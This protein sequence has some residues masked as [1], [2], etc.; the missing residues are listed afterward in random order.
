[1]D[2]IV[3]SNS[4][5][6]IGDNAS[7]S[8]GLVRVQEHP[9]EALEFYSFPINNTLISSWTNDR[10]WSIHPKLHVSIYTT[11]YSWFY[12]SR[13]KSYVDAVHITNGMTVNDDSQNAELEK[14][15]VDKDSKLCIAGGYVIY[16]KGD[17]GVRIDGTLKFYNTDTKE[18]T[19]T[20][21]MNGVEQKIV[22][23]DSG[24]LD[25]EG[26]FTWIIQGDEDLKVELTNPIISSS[27]DRLGTLSL[28]YSSI[29]DIVKYKSFSEYLDDPE[30]SNIK[31]FIAND[32][33]IRFTTRPN[34][35]AITF[36][37][38]N[39]SEEKQ[40]GNDKIWSIVDGKEIYL[41]IDGA[42]YYPCKN[43]ANLDGV[44]IHEGQSV[45]TGGNKTMTEMTI[46]GQVRVQGDITFAVNSGDQIINVGENGKIV[47]DDTKSLTISPTTGM[48][49]ENNGGSITGTGTCTFKADPNKVEYCTSTAIADFINNNDITSTVILT[50]IPE[51]GESLTYYFSN[52]DE[53][54][55]AWT[56]NDKV[57]SL[58]NGKRVYVYTTRYYYPGMNAEIKDN[59]VIPEGKIVTEGV[60]GVSF[61]DM[62]VD[63]T[64]KCTDSHIIYLS[65]NLSI[66]EN[67]SLIGLHAKTSNAGRI[68]I[69]NYSKL[70]GS[71]VPTLGSILNNFVILVNNH[72]DT[73]MTFYSSMNEM[74]WGT[75]YQ[76]SLR[77]D[78]A[79]YVFINGGYYY[80]GS[81]THYPDD[82]VVI[83]SG[84]TI[85]DNVTINNLNT[86]G[87][88]TV[89]SGA[90]FNQYYINDKNV[91]A[92][93]HLK[94]TGNVKIDGQIMS[95]ETSWSYLYI[96][97]YD[98]LTFDADNLD[99]INSGHGCILVYDVYPTNPTFYARTVGEKTYWSS[100]YC[101]QLNKQGKHIY[102]VLPDGVWYYPGYNEVND[103]NVVIPAGV[104]MITNQ[105]DK[106]VKSM[107][108]DGQLN[109]GGYRMNVRDGI[110]G[111]GRLQESAKENLK[112]LG[113]T[114]E[115]DKYEIYNTG[116]WTHITSTN[117]YTYY[118]N[119]GTSDPR[120]W[121][122]T[123]RLTENWWRADKC[124]KD[125][126][127]YTK[128]SDGNYEYY[129]PRSSNDT[130]TVS[131]GE[132]IVI[133]LQR[134]TYA[135]VVNVEGTLEICRDSETIDRSEKSTDDGFAWLYVSELN[136]K[137]S[138]RIILCEN[139][140]ITKEG[141]GK[142]LD[143]LNIEGGSITG[144][145]IIYVN[146]I[147]YDKSSSV[148]KDFVNQ[149]GTIRVVPKTAPDTY[150]SRMPVDESGAHTGYLVSNDNWSLDEDLKSSVSSYPGKNGPN[151]NL[152]VMPDD[153]VS[154]N[155]NNATFDNMTL[156]SGSTFKVNGY[157]LNV[158]NDINNDGNLILGSSRTA[159]VNGD[160]KGSGIVT[161]YSLENLIVYGKPS[162]KKYWSGYYEGE[163]RMLAKPL[164]ELTF[165]A[166]YSGDWV[167]G[168]NSRWTMDPDGNKLYL[169]DNSFGYVSPGCEISGS[170]N[171]RNSDNVVIKSG[172]EITV[173]GDISIDNLT[174]E[175]GA[176]LRICGGNLSV[177]GTADIKGQVVICDNGIDGKDGYKLLI[178]GGLNVVDN[179]CL[180]G[181]GWISAPNE[182]INKSS[183]PGR[184]F[185]A[186]GGHIHKSN[187]P[188]LYKYNASEGNW[189]TKACWDVWD[190]ETSTWKSQSARYP[191]QTVGD[192]A[193]VPVGSKVI[194]NVTVYLSELELNG[195]VTHDPKPDG[196]MPA[197]DDI[198]VSEKM[199]G[200]GILTLHCLW[201]IHISGDN[202][203]FSNYVDEHGD[204]QFA[205]GITRVVTSPTSGG[206]SPLQ[207]F[208]RGT[209]NWKD[210]DAVWSIDED[211]NLFWYPYNSNTGK[212]EYYYPYKN[213][214]KY[215]V[216][217]PAGADITF[218]GIDSDVDNS[219]SV[220]GLT[221]DGKLTICGSVLTVDGKTVVN[222][223]I[224]ICNDDP[225]NETTN[226]FQCTGYI[227]LNGVITG[228]DDNGT[229]RLRV[230]AENKIN[231]GAHGSYEDILNNGQLLITSRIESVQTFYSAQSGDWKSN[232]KSMWKAGDP[233]KNIYY[234]TT[235]SEEYE[236]RYTELV[237]TPTVKKDES[238]NDV[239]DEMG[240]PVYEDVVTSVEKSETR[241]K[242]VYGY[243]APGDYQYAYYYDRVV[244]QS[245]HTMTL[246]LDKLCYIRTLEVEE[247]ATL[248]VT[249]GDTLRV[250][251]YTG[252]LDVTVNGKMVLCDNAVLRVNSYLNGTGEL[253][254]PK[255]ENLVMAYPK[256]NNLANKDG[257]KIIFTSLDTP[258][259]F[260]S[261][262]YS[263]DWTDYRNWVVDVVNPLDDTQPHWYYGYTAFNGNACDPQPSDMYYPGKLNQADC[264][265]VSEGSNLILDAPVTLS[266]IEINGNLTV[267]QSN[268]DNAVY[269]TTTGDMVGSSDG[270]LTLEYAENIAVQGDNNF[271]FVGKIVIK[272][273]TEG[274]VFYLY[275]SDRD[276]TDPLN[277]S[278]DPNV[279]TNEFFDGM[280]QRW[281]Y[282]GKVL[283]D[284][285]V[286]PNGKNARVNKNVIVG[287]LK[288]EYGGNIFYDDDQIKLAVC[289]K[290]D[291]Y[292]NSYGS[293]HVYDLEKNYV[294]LDNCV[295]NF[296]ANGT[297]EV[298]KPCVI[299]AR[300]YG[301]LIVN[302]ASYANANPPADDEEYQCRV[303]GDITINKNLDVENG[304]VLTLGKD[305]LKIYY[306]RAQLYAKAK[307]G[308]NLPSEYDVF[309]NVNVKGNVTV[310]EGGVLRGASVINDVR[311]GILNYT[312]L[313]VWSNMD[314]Y[315]DLIV[316]GRLDFAVP[317]D[318]YGVHGAWAYSD[319]KVVINFKGS[320]DAMFKVDGFAS[321]ISMICEKSTNAE[322]S[323]DKADDAEF[324]M[325]GKVAMPD[326]G[327]NS[328]SIVLNS[329]ILR[330]GSGIEVDGWG[331]SRYSSNGYPQGNLEYSIRNRTS[332]MALYHRTPYY[333]S[334]LVS[335]V[336]GNEG[337][338]WRVNNDQF[339]T[340]DSFKLKY[341]KG[342]AGW[343]DMES[344]SDYYLDLGTGLEYKW[345][346]A[347]TIFKRD[348]EE[349]MV[350]PAGAKLIIDGA[351][352][353]VGRGHTSGQIKSD[354]AFFGHMTLRG[355]LE[356]T[357][358][359][360]L[361]FDNY[362]V[363]IV[364]DNPDGDM[365]SPAEIAI[366]DGGKI[367]VSRIYGLHG[368]KLNFSM[369]GE[370]S[371]LNFNRNTNGN[372]KTYDDFFKTYGGG[373]ITKGKPQGCVFS[374][375]NGGS[376][377]MEDGRILF[378]NYDAAQRFVVN[379]MDL[380]NCS[381]HFG[382]G[383]LRFE[384][385]TTAMT[386]YIPNSVHLHDVSV[387]GDQYV[388][389]V[390]DGYDATTLGYS[391]NDLYIDGNLTI[392]MLKGRMR[393]PENLHVGGNIY[394]RQREGVTYT[395][396]INE[397]TGE[398]ELVASKYENLADQTKPLYASY[399]TG[400]NSPNL[401]IM[402]SENSVLEVPVESSSYPIFTHLTV[403]KTSPTATFT[404]K[405]RPF[406]MWGDLIVSRG[407]VITETEFRN[408]DYSHAVDNE[409]LDGIV[410]G[411]IKRV[412]KTQ[413]VTVDDEGDLSESTISTWGDNTTYNLNINSNVT[414]KNFLSNYDR[415]IILNN[416]VT[417]SVTDRFEMPTMNGNRM[418]V[419]P[420]ATDQIATGGLCVP[421]RKSAGETFT[422]PIGISYINANRALAYAY[423]RSVVT[424]NE[425]VDGYMQAMACNNWH[426]QVK[427]QS[428][429]TKMYWRM[430]WKD[431]K[432][433]DEETGE[434]STPLVASNSAFTYDFSLPGIADNETPAY[435]TQTRN[436]GNSRQHEGHSEGEVASPSYWEYTK[437]YQWVESD[438]KWYECGRRQ[439]KAVA[440]A[441]YPTFPYGT[442]FAG[443]EYSLPSHSGDF[444]DGYHFDTDAAPK[445][446]YSCANGEWDDCTSWTL[447]EDFVYDG[448]LLVP[449]KLDRVVIG[450]GYKITT[451]ATSKVQAAKMTINEDGTLDVS[452]SVGVVAKKSSKNYVG[453]I[454][455]E[456][457]LIYHVDPAQD[458]IK[459]ID[460]TN[461]L[462]GDHSEFLTNAKSKLVYVND[463]PE[464]VKLPDVITEYP[465]L[466]IEGNAQFVNTT[467]G[468]TVNG[469]LEIEKGLLE[470]GCA[471]S[472]NVT[473]KGDLVVGENGKLMTSE[474]ETVSLSFKKKIVNNGE[475]VLGK[476]SAD[477]E[478]DI[479]NNGEF[480]VAGP[481]N[482]VSIS[483]TSVNG[484]LIKISN[485]GVLVLNK[486]A[487]TSSLTV[488]AEIV[489]E[490]SD[491]IQTD[492]KRGVLNMSCLTTDAKF[493]TYRN[494]LLSQYYD[495]PL[496]VT[497]NVKAG[498]VE[499]SGTGASSLRLGGNLSVANA[500]LKT[501]NGL[502]YTTNGATMTLGENSKF[503]ASQIAPSGS[504]GAFKFNQASSNATVELV[505]STEGNLYNTGWGILDIR[506]GEFTQV[507]GA[508][509]DIK[510]S[511]QNV[512]IPTL[513]YQPSTS[514]L[515][516]NSSFVL[517]TNDD[518]SIY[519]AHALQGLNVA[520]GTNAAVNTRPLVL[521]STLVVDGELNMNDLNLTLNADAVI[522]GRYVSGD[523]TTYLSSAT[524]QTISG[525]AADVEFNNVV[526]NTASTTTIKLPQAIVNG[527]LSVTNGKLNIEDSALRMKGATATVNYTRSITGLGVEMCGDS[528]QQ[529]L[530]EG[531][532]GTLI[533]NN[534]NG[535]NASTSQT[536]PLK[537]SNELRMTDGVLYIGSN[538][539]ELA[540]TAQVTD[541]DGSGWRAGKLIKTNNVVA[542]AGIK[543][544]LPS[545]GACDFAIPMGTE[546][547]YTPITLEGSQS[548]PNAFVRIVPV[549]GHF[550][551]IEDNQK[552]H[553]MKYYWL[554]ESEGINDLNG[555]LHFKAEKS[556]ANGFDHD[557]TDPSEGGYVTAV[558]FDGKET[559]NLAEGII[560]DDGTMVLIDI[561]LSNVSSTGK[562][563]NGYYMAGCM[564]KLPTEVKTYISV[565]DGD[566]AEAIWK[567]YR[568]NPV[569]NIREVVDG[570]SFALTDAQMVGCAIYINSRVK[571]SDNVKRVGSVEIMSNA[572][573]NIG[574]TLNHF[575][576]Y[577]RGTGTM[578]LYS[579]NMPIANYEDFLSS[580]GGT[581]EFS[582]DAQTLRKDY[583]ILVGMTS[584]NHLKLSGEGKRCFRTDGG[585][586]D[587]YGTFT[588]DGSSNLEAQSNGP[589]R[590][591]GNVLVNSGQL[592]GTGTYVFCNSS[593]PQYLDNQNGGAITIGGVE[594][595]N[596]RGVTMSDGTDLSLTSLALTD[597]ILH[598]G[599]DNKVT[600]SG[601]LS[602]GSANSYVDGTLGVSMTS[603]QSLL[604]P[605]GE[606]NRYA[607]PVITA[608]KADVL[609]VRYVW[610]KADLDSGHKHNAFCSTLG[611][612]YWNIGYK[613]G[614]GTVSVKLPY[615]EESNI[616]ANSSDLRLARIYNDKVS[617]N[618]S[619]LAMK[620]S[621]SNMT[622]GYV[623]TTSNVSVY[624]WSVGG[625]SFAFGLNGVSDYEWTGKVSADWFDGNNWAGR[626]VPS[627][628]NE[629]YIKDGRGVYPVISNADMVAYARHIYIRGTEPTLTVNGGNLY[630]AWQICIED[631]QNQHMFINNR[632]DKMSNVRT[633]NILYGTGASNIN[634]LPATTHV[635]V[636]RTLPANVLCYTGSA[637][638]QGSVKSG[639]NTSNGDYLAQ[640]NYKNE[641]YS[642]VSSFGTSFIGHTIGLRANDSEP[643]E[644]SFVQ[645]GS[646]LGTITSYSFALGLT[647]GSEKTSSPYGWNLITNPYTFSFPLE[648]GVFVNS[649]GVQPVI[650]FRRF[651][652]E[653]KKYYYS[654]FSL[655]TYEGVAASTTTTKLT[656]DDYY[657]AP[658]EAFFVKTLSAKQSVKFNVGYVTAD[659]MVTNS[660]L[661]ARKVATDVLR[662]SIE[663]DKSEFIDEVAF[664][665]RDGGTMES[666]MND[667]DKRFEGNSYNQ[668]YSFKDGGRYA[669]PFYPS[670][671]EVSD[672]LMPLGIQLAAGAAEGTI[673]ATNLDVFDQN[674]EVYLYD[675]VEDIVVNLRETGEYQF[676][677][678]SGYKIDDRFA[679]GLVSNVEEEQVVKPEDENA[680]GVLSVA[681]DGMIMI[682]RNDDNE[683]VVS[684]SSSLLSEESVVNVYDM[685]GVLVNKSDIKSVKTRVKLGETK[686]V[687]IVE[688]ISGGRTKTAK[689]RSM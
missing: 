689:L 61:N 109:Q 298:L 493:V 359:G 95:P 214:S 448:N 67:A 231:L 364:Y 305:I 554:I 191:G 295:D 400:N 398:E 172:K 146:E 227:D 638:K 106:T 599:I 514:E 256:R 670:M 621:A 136:L 446:F 531:T 168:E 445:T 144:N 550:I 43:T 156:R 101:W 605:V 651:N 236:Y 234:F 55:N 544:Y 62:T 60:S 230:T 413:N 96:S 64:Y 574:N 132:H 355:A 369:S 600:V 115:N 258:V 467:K 145:G 279:Y 543:K 226:I 411:A 375:A 432:V 232:V 171:S 681:E 346:D 356:V 656:S 635:V 563:L 688:V 253:Y 155:L 85:Y 248:Y 38:T 672:V 321:I 217:I 440:G 367:N 477:I 623:C 241:T 618:W 238:G 312:G 63:G 594:I 204:Y 113:S 457:T 9:G 520:S 421:V 498:K 632:Y 393:T 428:T 511:A 265:V 425:D 481:I 328:W 397:E 320:N 319:R 129:Y 668:I 580:E 35:E 517:N 441:G 586:T 528:E 274:T 123:D 327:R 648:S 88:F 184:S 228:T 474:D 378:N 323:V 396:Q 521:N 470:L 615:D 583:N 304:S 471:S 81:N 202:P 631:G 338:V 412:N 107:V 602:G 368:R 45:R 551:G 75:T 32:G 116:E 1:M 612:E 373:D 555:S 326:Y 384:N 442:D 657:I 549:D 479:D 97:D 597:G 559:W 403:S 267:A 533:I 388:T 453:V 221:V 255:P 530:C 177:R 636:N 604:F 87:D 684:V 608:G 281:R 334:A 523:N 343:T 587:I 277:W 526:K 5:L 27:T 246:S 306:T 86:I 365:N 300:E 176:I 41:F 566:W 376:F 22:F 675:F 66:G 402:G 603:G 18:Y 518:I 36:Y 652:N 513:Y 83:Q 194:L 208:A 192:K 240:N 478:G 186:Q 220:A 382:G 70:I 535:V 77:R 439:T 510:G 358:N 611:N 139:A 296:L 592:T 642:N 216:Q 480:T 486:E 243:Y 676:T 454:L 540:S 553:V 556:D 360:V 548:S 650:W 667:A 185:V 643:L 117:P 332:N 392:D 195:E 133:S 245:G 370:D 627:A 673:S 361:N 405:G 401:F 100:S 436:C 13:L 452:K 105:N 641:G 189:N 680:T 426:P 211:A 284:V 181:G 626:I 379:G 48:K 593:S 174:V 557:S 233:N 264:V 484:N 49:W 4:M 73:A 289:F 491:Y 266:S 287:Y 292:N 173:N 257:G 414:V 451:D 475:V 108:L 399:E 187:S 33:K 138:G 290:T 538:P 683:A 8:T 182:V 239:L 342:V 285:A 407:K 536:Y 353:N 341:Q 315:G 500:E 24:V 26:D 28:S 404:I 225:S 308:E 301:S 142:G 450:N 466:V 646:V 589:I 415:R 190:V 537:I 180:T 42:Y 251:S 395:S 503:V 309:V 14:L 381:A 509:I 339:G 585:T 647:A 6:T 610:G 496:G 247:G 39:A 307:A 571:I 456:G 502:G 541:G 310:S 235:Y 135:K 213:A 489:A 349:G 10:L 430:N 11:D 114:P 126:Y 183:E 427:D 324:Y 674:T 645:E 69:D 653:S 682:T 408:D 406:Y 435:Y 497:L 157:A 350:I 464:S 532:I 542:D 29:V 318:G 664:V 120:N 637:T 522:N 391:S 166:N 547:K 302:Y 482:F 527:N 410:F 562:D 92:N 283:S 539:I 242:N 317:N 170:I 545:S 601:S 25:I 293:I 565:L 434:E 409:Y 418:F 219:A 560:S 465:T 633:F 47:I 58:V 561:P 207:F 263:S 663:S 678:A 655:A 294:T 677:S 249:G 313:P 606:G 590:L 57:W 490:G 188:Q 153:I 160:L 98:K 23:G 661:K 223:E 198:Y 311:N 56:K 17:D 634:K 579:G 260:I 625:C 472:K 200:T 159:I 162:D 687:Y 624:R 222:G 205:T 666:T 273:E 325:N 143:L 344:T 619:A 512:D 141:S 209:H 31:E 431:R 383:E 322:L 658:Q 150:Y 461:Y 122:Y 552:E 598:V 582:S 179:N 377:N 72:D 567:E 303:E 447:S 390:G 59:V 3:N 288:N 362:S 175:S 278:T 99:L 268:G 154:L 271:F 127:Y 348:L 329:G 12:P 148:A 620:V 40:W 167:D 93:V 37:L 337:D 596:H 125:V 272:H 44:V 524:T 575:F 372:Y 121:N 165:Y 654:T 423:T 492:L 103:D 458:W 91:K 463:D 161:L 74:N 444:T 84:H 210:N 617:N 433:T 50:A 94:T 616:D 130:V 494:G 352:V 639:F 437:Y 140:R 46:D 158:N 76:W 193:V 134:I 78:A 206:Y 507:S 119:T 51:C 505:G 330:L 71:G 669:I 82:N 429:A 516:K 570:E 394:I 282:P 201:H 576:G 424:V 455:G 297:V 164:S 163:T 371:E 345:L 534:S 485:S 89:E 354:G 519:I 333:S 628:S 473:I 614:N 476:S 595:N 499:L 178:Y 649:A 573:L 275:N 665:F 111:S 591:Y 679:I 495:L 79:V 387:Y 104:E 363:G 659:N 270:V 54:G 487:E 7:S 529:L 336:A 335:A 422:M 417:F 671:S 449:T 20:F 460:R 65:G 124:R 640:Y 438:G 515:S 280:G 215:M 443:T 80:P 462:Q 581:L 19:S 483:N 254:M 269:L 53:A 276:W 34:D 488:N 508:K 169:Y 419:N 607:A 686:G 504:T 21:N 102:Y 52:I 237:T 90:T 203:F 340:D 420:A 244:I 351:T 469:N 588:V 16:V 629:V 212:Y 261:T 374:M 389:F 568:L 662:L 112:A 152:V 609:Y 147:G 30:N 685:I 137:S 316:N 196:T 224:H 386:V 15:V 286:I 68:V 564:A 262:G 506:G 613:G 110:S 525:S 347:Y 644:R 577:V 380:S 250:N 569:T 572:E 314:V 197:S 131:A 366:K 151:D 2:V 218:T 252:N 459:R 660:K 259:K 558:Y 578:I 546:T 468:L 291:G 630:V 199:T 416:N 149:G 128:N 501:P 229:G 622:T 357:N 299:P 331:A 118:S 385:K 584:V